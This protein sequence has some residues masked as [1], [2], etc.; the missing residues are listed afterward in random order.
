MIVL[1]RVN[2]HQWD[3]RERLTMPSLLRFLAIVAILC[4]LVYAGLYSLAHFVQ[5]NPREI[6]VSIPPDKFFK[7]H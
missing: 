6:S 3:E 2:R 4:A 7:N 1:A 5:P